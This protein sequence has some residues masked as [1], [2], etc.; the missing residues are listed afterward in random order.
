M[1]FRR[2]R[3]VLRA[4]MRL[5]LLGKGKF[6]DGSVT[7]ST[8]NHGGQEQT[9]AFSMHECGD[10]SG[11]HIPTDG[12][13]AF[14]FVSQRGHTN[15]SHQA[16][17]DGQMSEIHRILTCTKLFVRK[18][19]TSILD[20][21]LFSNFHKDTVLYKQAAHIVSWFPDRPHHS[22][23]LTLTPHLRLVDLENCWE[24]VEFVTKIF[25]L[26]NAKHRDLRI[27]GGLDSLERQEAFSRLCMLP[28]KAVCA[29]I[30][31]YYRFNLSRLSERDE[32]ITLV[33]L[34]G[35]LKEVGECFRDF[36]Q[37]H[38]HHGG[39]RERLE[40]VWNN[41]RIDGRI[42]ALEKALHI[43]DFAVPFTGMMEVDLVDIRKPD[44]RIDAIDSTHFLLLLSQLREKVSG[45][46]RMEQIVET[47][48]E[49]YFTCLQ[50]IILQQLFKGADSGY[51]IEVCVCLFSRT[52]DWRAYHYVVKYA[53]REERR[54]ATQRI[55]HLNLFFDGAATAV[56]YWKLDLRYDQYVLIVSALL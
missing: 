14:E 46:A 45:R 34:T 10:V 39:P 29:N 8:L 2:S 9:R 28:R 32:C 18:D 6:V 7:H 11:G 15:V 47:S 31:G 4:L 13:L 23:D 16:L 50:V 43:K 51:R 20:Q 35:Q 48:F 49:N 54:I 42:A 1:Y 41:V 21:K 17:T 24:R 25:P 26:L 53:G 38:Q 52:V 55:G 36:G 19:R 37:R 40:L 3:N 22:G 5:V 12:W 44:A 33:S 30:S 27:L 56:G